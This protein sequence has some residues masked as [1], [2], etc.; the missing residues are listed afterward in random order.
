MET[1][2]QIA[3]PHHHA[4]AGTRKKRLIRRPKGSSW[5]LQDAMGLANDETKY[6]RVVVRA[7][8]C[9]THLADP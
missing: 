1:E 8:L 6:K 5:S 2:T 4:Q 9:A 3:Q 7:L